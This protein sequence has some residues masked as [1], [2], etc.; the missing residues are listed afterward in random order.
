MRAE[1]WQTHD[2]PGSVSG[3]QPA[4]LVSLM[5]SGASWGEFA[6]HSSVFWRLWG[7]ECFGTGSTC[8]HR[9]L[10][11]ELGGRVGLQILGLWWE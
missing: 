9:P 7:G 6:A 4:L 3:R 10:D 5:L 11:I 2:G 1:I 8:L